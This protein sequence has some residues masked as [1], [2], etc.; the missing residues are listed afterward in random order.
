MLVCT[1]STIL[2]FVL[3]I[4]SQTVLAQQ[5]TTKGQFGVSAAGSAQYTIP[6][7]VPAGIAGLEPHLALNYDSRA[8]NGM[9]GVGWTL[10]GLSSIMPCP[11]TTAQDANQGT[12]SYHLSDRFCLDGE[13]LIA[14]AGDYGADGTEY[15]TERDTFVKIVSHGVSY[16]YTDTG[17]NSFTVQTKSGQTM[18]F[19]DT[20]GS[21]APNAR[22]MAAGGNCA[23]N[24]VVKGW[25]LSKI[26]DKAG[27][28][29]NVTYANYSGTPIDQ[30]TCP[31][32]PSDDGLF[33]PSRIDYGGNRS[34]KKP[35]T[36]SVTFYW[37]AGT[38]DMMMPFRGGYRAPRVASYLSQINMSVGG[39]AVEYYQLS[40]DTRRYLYFP[41]RLTSVAEC[42]LAPGATC[43][44]PIV[45]NW[46]TD[47]VPFQSW[48][49]GSAFPGTR[50]D[51]QQ[52][53]VDVNGDGKKYWLQISQSADDA[54]IGVAKSDGTFSTDRWTKFTTPIGALDNYAHYFADVN[55]DGKADWIRVSKTTNEAWIALGMGNGQFQ[56]WSKYT[57]AVGSAGG[58]SHYFA[59]VD[60]DGRA[61]WIQIRP[62]S[63]TYP[64]TTSVALATGDGNFQFW[65]KTAPTPAGTASNLYFVDVN[66]DGKSDE[67]LSGSSGNATF[68][69]NGDG[70]FKGVGGGSFGQGK[71]YFADINGDGVADIVGVLPDGTTYYAYGQGNGT[72]TAKYSAGPTWG[73]DQFADIGGDGIARRIS[74]TSGVPGALSAAYDVGGRNFAGDLGLRPTPTD[75]NDGTYLADSFQAFFADLNGDGK[76]DLIL[77][78][79]VTK[80]AWVSVSKLVTTGKIVSISTPQIDP[81]RITYKPLN[82]PSVYTPDT[83]AVYPLRDSV[84]PALRAPRMPYV[85]SSVASP[86]GIGGT[87]TT[88]YTYGGQKTDLA[89][90]QVL[91]FRWTQAVQAETGVTTRTDY[92][93][94]WPYVGLA[95]T[96][97]STLQ[98]A[99][100]NGLLSQASYTYG[101]NDFVTVGGCTVAPGK[102]Y[103]PFTSQSVSSSW[104][105]N[106]A[107]L[108]VTTTSYQ[109]DAFGDPTQVVTSTSDGHTSTSTTSYTNDVTHWWIGMP[110]RTSVVNTAP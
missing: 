100:N 10:S 61:D 43:L 19:G 102:R 62:S 24:L 25:A 20:D 39:Q 18:I 47:A 22:I 35:A 88:N 105:L 72:Y 28:F 49:S 89:R 70:T 108:P 17:P 103:F 75:P 55:G 29:L 94:D 97:K 110:V 30:N 80:E 33:Y 71:Y 86:N 74:F 91:G 106:D 64:S 38:G 7:K 109:F 31:V 85:V 90:R 4:L 36:I 68:I 78:N 16:P 98:G 5:L 37:E 79:R 27:N 8:G 51:Y 44:P 23:A 32:Y 56:F 73:V 54:W 52:F 99:G 58:Y 82:D 107:V 50:S 26:T 15:R 40:Y 60:G 63:A 59:D 65:T 104:D 11:Q 76:D 66:G 87:V 14:V 92:H 83:D 34:A 3:T 84:Y 53:F 9:L 93:L 2:L 6:I 41:G 81:T 1:R 96:S 77:I 95:A 13:R 42:F 12:V 21:I 69:S 48:T 67:V 101:C 57:Q 45:F 46:E